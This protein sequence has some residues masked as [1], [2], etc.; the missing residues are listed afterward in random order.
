MSLKKNQ[1]TNS[2][3]FKWSGLG[4]YVR[5]TV[6]GQSKSI[7]YDILSPTVARSRCPKKNIRRGCA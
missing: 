5:M 4:H 2:V 7:S 6:L 1:T 3:V